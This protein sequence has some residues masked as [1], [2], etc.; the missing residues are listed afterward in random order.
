MPSFVQ[1]RRRIAGAS[2][3]P[4]AAGSLE[5]ELSINF[6]G[7]AGTA[8]TPEIWL[9]DG[10]GWRRANP[11]GVSPNVRGVTAVSGGATVQAAF[12]A[13]AITVAAGDIVIYTH[14]G[15]AYVYTGPTGVVTTATAANFTALGAA[16]AIATSAQIRV[17]TNNTAA[18]T[19][20]ALAAV[21]PP[22]TLAAGTSGAQAGHPT[23]PL[24]ATGVAADAGRIVVLDATGKVPAALLGVAGLTF[25]AADI[26]AAKPG[27][28]VHANGTVVTNTAAAAGPV[29]ASWSVAGNP[30]VQPGDM[31]L[32]D[33]T[34]WHHIT[35][36]IDLTNVVTKKGPQALD[37]TWVGTMTASAAKM[38]RLDGGDNKKSQISNFDLTN[39][40]LDGGTF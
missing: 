40:T 39:C 28:I 6:P 10:T 17:G 11:P 25:K 18:V 15:T 21:L 5:G 32:S 7:A 37:A 1:H 13:D 9:Y 33:G 3:A 36:A 8:A 38:V 27:T 19:P 22:T 23:N 29:H 12:N 31:L 14:A 16:M 4:A 2:G 24:A 30:V 34:A 35:S 20:L 26:T